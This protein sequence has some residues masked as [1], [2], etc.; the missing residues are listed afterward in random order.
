M[1]A[2]TRM[3]MIVKKSEGEM[4]REVGGNQR[5]D[6]LHCFFYCL[7]LLFFTELCSYGGCRMSG[8][9]DGEDEGIKTE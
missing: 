6:I 4:F 5:R 9:E 1:K 8:R 3:A 7:T 2:D